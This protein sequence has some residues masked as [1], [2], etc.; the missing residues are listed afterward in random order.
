MQLGVA[1]TIRIIR[2]LCIMYAIVKYLNVKLYFIHY[3][4]VMYAHIYLRQC[5]VMV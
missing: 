1:I 3:G 2:V 4:S 5:N